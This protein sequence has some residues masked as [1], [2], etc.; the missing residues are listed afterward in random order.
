M[1]SIEMLLNE[2]E[3][4]ILRAKKAAF[5]STD[6]IVNK[7]ALL[8]LI[9]RFRAAFPLSIKEAEQIKKERDEI[10]SKAEAY[11]NDTMDKAEVRARQLISETEVL[12]QATAD[13]ESMRGEAEENYRK[14]DYE[15][16]ALAFSI[17]DGAEKI[18]KES[19]NT[20][21]DRKRKLIEN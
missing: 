13:A 12:R 4:E 20:I 21:G 6:I 7:Q 18:I 15:A 14:M 1:E 19:L 16:R 10:L 17:L 8:S 11:A 9:T 2:I 3:G 5:S